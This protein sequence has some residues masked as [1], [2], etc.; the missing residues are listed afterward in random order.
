[1]AD[2]KNDFHEKEDLSLVLGGPLYQLYLR[3][4]LA[5]PPIHLV[6]RRIFVF[7]LITWLPLLVLTFIEGHALGGV[8]VPFLL[9]LGA[10]ARFFGS[11]P[12]FIAAE[13]IVH[14]HVG[15]KI[16]KFLD[17]K[18]IAP[19]DL[20]RFEKAV[21]SSIRLRNSV[22]I[23][24]ILFL[25]AFVFG[26]WL[27]SRFLTLHLATWYAD[28]DEPLR[29]T[30]AGYWFAFVSLPIFRFVML[31]WYFRIIVWY[32]LL[33]RISRIPLQLN[34][35]HPDQAGGLGFL[36]KSVF[37]FTLVLL[38]HTVFLAGAIGNQIWHRHAVLTQFKLEIIGLIGFL[39]LL[40]LGPLLFFVP[41]M[42]RAKRSG[43]GE[44]NVFAMEYVNEFKQKW[45][46]TQHPSEKPLG[47]A[48]I[49]SLADLAGSYDAAREMR[50]FPFGKDAVIGLAIVMALPLAPL[51]LTMIPLDEM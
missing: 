29:L 23:E 7:F 25:I 12:L 9:D 18:L 31:R 20:P 27:W 34:A 51:T 37:A 33:W 3:T 22:S 45:L 14:E 2:K 13:M 5:R 8:H 19:E 42:I 50:F 21:K 39:M 36:G 44:Y 15:S 47:A 41:Q 28:V 35:L 48:D 49:Q 24:I 11:L 6:H 17:M 38:D 4:R 10:Q 32:F 30:F 46:D 16:R 1:M 26:Y 43:K 40:V